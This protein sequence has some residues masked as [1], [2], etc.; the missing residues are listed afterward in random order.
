MNPP[1]A[2]IVEVDHVPFTLRPPHTLA[3]IREDAGR[4]GR[5]W[6]CRLRHKRR[7]VGNIYYPDDLIAKTFVMMASGSARALVR[8]ER[9]GTIAVEMAA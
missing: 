3:S 9:C 1:G 7:V 4:K 2:E 5:P 6:L 8:C